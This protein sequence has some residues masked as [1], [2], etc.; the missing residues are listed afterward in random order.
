MHL[1]YESLQNTIYETQESYYKVTRIEKEENSNLEE[2]TEELIREK[3]NL[4]EEIWQI[5]I[6]SIGLEAPIAE[7]T[8]QEIMRDYVG[9]FENTN[10]WEGNIGLAAHNRRFPNKLF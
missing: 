7:G 1:A 10:L 4:Q 5:E 3:I 9:H 8:T 6:P 2:K